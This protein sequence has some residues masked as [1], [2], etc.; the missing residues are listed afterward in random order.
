MTKDEIIDLIKDLRSFYVIT[1]Y[2]NMN[3]KLK[4]I[5]DKS[6]NSVRVMVI[7][8]NG[9]EDVYKRQV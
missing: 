1:E 3:A 7:N 8:R 6:V 9:Y 5:Y 4:K 2:I